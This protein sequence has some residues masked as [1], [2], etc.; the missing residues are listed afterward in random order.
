MGI[1]SPVHL[2]FIAAI[3]LIVLGPK[4]LPDLARSLGHGMREFRDA[5]SGATDGEGHAHAPAPVPGQAQLTVSSESTPAKQAVD[6]AE[7]VRS[8]DAPD[9]RSL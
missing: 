5:M 8:G 2:I 9:R 6:P 4:R 1:E 3:A 7:P